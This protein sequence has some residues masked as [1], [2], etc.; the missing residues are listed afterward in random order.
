MLL[1]N[2]M[3]NGLSMLQLQFLIFVSIFKY[4]LYILT[5]SYHSVCNVSKDTADAILGWVVFEMTAPS[6]VASPMESIP[7]VRL[8]NGNC[9]SSKLMHWIQ[10]LASVGEKSAA[11]S[12]AQDKPHCWSP[13]EYRRRRWWGFRKGYFLVQVTALIWEAFVARIGWKYLGCS[14]PKL[15]I[16]LQTVGQVGALQ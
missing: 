3:W 5:I 16:H 7:Q 8:Q 12:S 1:R 4:S 2:N 9:D 13:H 11:K 6:S 15:P 14:F 10:T